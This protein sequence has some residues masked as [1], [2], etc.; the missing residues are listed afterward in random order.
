M[1]VL[2]I[3]VAL[4]NILVFS[5]PLTAHTQTSLGYSADTQ[6]GTIP[7]GYE[8]SQIPNCI[9]R[10]EPTN[11]QPV[12]QGY[13]SQTIATFKATVKINNTNATVDNL[14]ASNY[15]LVDGEVRMV[16]YDEKTGMLSVRGYDLT[17]NHNMVLMTY[18]VDTGDLTVYGNGRLTRTIYKVN[19]EMV[20]YDENG[21]AKVTKI[22]SRIYKSKKS[23]MAVYIRSGSEMMRAGGAL[24]EGDKND[25]LNAL[26][27]L[28][29]GREIVNPSSDYW[30]TVESFATTVQ[31]GTIASNG[32]SNTFSY[33]SD[34]GILSI[35][36]Y[37]L[38]TNHNMFL[39]TFDCISGDITVYGEQRGTRTV[40]SADG[41]GM[42]YDSINSTIT[43][44]SSAR[45]S[46][47]NK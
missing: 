3:I 21:V 12:L 7:V 44:V 27:I 14:E 10:E 25:F 5:F 40:Y 30:Q 16:N 18:N 37:D 42:F 29:T 28:F 20:N 24:T 17:S 22:D 33:N 41:E 45:T 19:G 8:S 35:R 26:R 6:S 43:T 32:T 1:K 11:I 15:N 9:N 46:K 13:N 39:M 31:K 4:A 2:K 34:T 36:G 47:G 38:K 23:E